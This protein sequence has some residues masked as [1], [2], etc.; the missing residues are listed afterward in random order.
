MRA[1][2][3]VRYGSPQEALQLEDVPEPVPGPNEVLVRTAASVCNYNEVDACYG[4]YLTVNPPLPYT[5]GMEVT[6]VVVGAGE[7]ARHWMGRRV[8]GVSS[9][10][11]GAHAELVVAAADMVFDVPDAL[12][13]VR[14]AAFC[15]PFHLAYLGLHERAHVQAGETVLVHA[16]AGGVGSAAVQ[17]AVA[18]GAR[19]IATAGGADKV[20][21]ARQLGADVA[22]DYRSGDFVDAVFEATDGRGVDLCFD[23]VGGDVMQQSLRCLTRGGR[24]LVVGFASGIEAEEVPMVTGR[25][26]CFGNLSVMGVILSYQDP[27][28]V[29]RGY[30]Y[31][32]FPPEVGRRVNDSLVA[33]LEAGTIHPVVGKT[34]AFEALPEALAEMA[35]RTT[36][37]RIVVQVGGGQRA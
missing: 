37:G 3:V 1:W 9:N 21:F 23:G 31:N 32:P 15:I 12:D 35:Q 27:A 13:D 10:A 22:I 28:T 7:L 26:F 29:P 36:M 20:E 16:A 5:L 25:T 2:R 4:R 24:H 19:V 33:L 14:A 8:M 17:L 6:G 30:G 34:V 11:T 18:A